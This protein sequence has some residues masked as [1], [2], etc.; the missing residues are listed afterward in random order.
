MANT[1]LARRINAFEDQV[2]VLAGINVDAIWA[3]LLDEY[4]SEWERL[5][6]LNLSQEEVA[7]RLESF[8]LDLSEKPLEGIA[9]KGA[10][11][12]YSYGRGAKILAAADQGE[13]EICV[14][15][16]VLDTRTCRV[17]AMYAMDPPVV[18]VDTPE[19]WALYPPAEC[20]GGDNCRGFYIPFTTDFLRQ[21][22]KTA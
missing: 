19:F 15:S 8:L 10:G 17:C 22:A 4:L 18:E 9:R 21:L 16:E 12:A 14:R 13:V 3:R 11:V 7:S 6:R 1:S 5:D 2:E 20:E